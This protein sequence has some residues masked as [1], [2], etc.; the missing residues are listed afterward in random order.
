VSERDVRPATGVPGEPAS[1]EREQAADVSLAQP[2]FGDARWSFLF[3][4]GDTAYAAPHADRQQVAAANLRMR[5]APAGAVHGPM[6]KGPVW[7]WE[8]PVYMWT[9]GIAA[10]SAFVALACDLTGDHRSAKIARKVALSAVLPA[11][12]LLTADLG[13]PGRFLNML[14]IIKPRSPMSTGAWCLVVFSGTLSGAVGA[15]LLGKPRAA[16]ALGALASVLG[17][18]LGSYTGALL[19]CT[20]VPVWARSRMVLGPIFVSTATATGAAATRLVL[21]ASGLPKGHPSRRA[22]STIETASIV[23]ELTLALVNERRLGGTAK[24][25]LRGRAGRVYWLA[26]ACV[27]LGL[28]SR[29]LARRA[30]RPAAHDLAS[31]L[32]LAGGLAFRI[33]WVNAGKASAADHEDVAAT[34]RSRAR[35]HSLSTERRPL[36]LRG[37][38]RSWAEAVRRVSLKVERVLQ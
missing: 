5:S 38:R 4:E 15:D 2:G 30:D 1:W 10:G 29:L 24:S 12:L 16:R 18:Y 19:A 36:P 32:Y 9:G 14:R 33:A 13:R 22:L 25:L 31:A 27:I 7:T 28:G 20:A 8:I 35:A 23:T 3:K 11:P 6:I 17:G 21:V 37:A 26:R 34:A